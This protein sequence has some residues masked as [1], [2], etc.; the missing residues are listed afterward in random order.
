ME[1]PK[2]QNNQHRIEWEKQSQMT[3]TIQLKTRLTTANIILNC[4]DLKAFPLISGTSQWYLLLP[5]LFN[6]VLEILATAMR[7]EKEKES[8][9]ENK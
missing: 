8:R 3:D 4:E 2:L 5:L 1:K 6:R 9:L 7:E